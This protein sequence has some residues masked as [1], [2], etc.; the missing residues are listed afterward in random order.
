MDIALLGGTGDI[1]QALALRWAAD[2]D[3][4]VVIGSREA[5]RARQ[6]ADEYEAELASRG[7]DRTVEA[8]DNAAAAE[9]GEVVVLAVPPYYVRGVVEGID[10]V[11]GDAVLVNPGVGIERDETGFNYN[12]PGV[13]SV[14]ELVAET[15]PD[16][17]RVVGAY[18]NLPAGRLANLDEDLEMD[19]LVVGDDEDAKET[20]VTL[21]EEIRGLGALDAGPLANASEIEALTPLLLTVKQYNDDARDLGVRFT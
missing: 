6:K 5:S 21:T 20:V 17:N 1:G 10:D 11:V 15:A 4:G 19:T 16:P 2:T 18:H 13:G 12:P 3:H 8:G 14:T 9:A 7:I